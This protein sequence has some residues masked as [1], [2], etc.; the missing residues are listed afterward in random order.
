MRRTKEALEP[1]RE[2]GVAGYRVARC[3]SLTR[4]GLLLL[5]L[6]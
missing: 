4:F 5:T 1:S 2:D 6:Y 3:K